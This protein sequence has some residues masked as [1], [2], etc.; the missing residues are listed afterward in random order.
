[1]KLYGVLIFFLC[2]LA[3]SANAED[4]KLPKWVTDNVPA[5]QP[6]QDG[7]V[8][9]SHAAITVAHAIWVSANPEIA[10]KIGDERTWQR[11]MIATL[12]DGVWEV[13]SP[14]KSGEVGGSLFIFIA[15]KDGRV[16]NIS[17]T[18]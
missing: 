5:W 8:R 2:L 4:E 6:P 16:L 18:Q 17:L 12:N 11:D 7:L 3:P 9:D 1:M 10:D 14:M 13:T 15:K